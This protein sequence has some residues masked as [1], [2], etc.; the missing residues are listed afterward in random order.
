M[1]R[2]STKLFAA[3]VTLFAILALLAISQRQTTP[4]D[5]TSS[6]RTIATGVAQNVIGGDGVNK[7]LSKTAHGQVQIEVLRAA[8]QVTDEIGAEA[9]RS[10]EQYAQQG[11]T[12]GELNLALVRFMTTALALVLTVL[13]ILIPV[14]GLIK[15]M[16]PIMRNLR[17]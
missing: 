16:S 5:S 12:Y 17:W 11:H 4:G 13:A 3:A 10:A 6:D 7:A 1:P 8:R 9:E 14:A 15:V 2:S